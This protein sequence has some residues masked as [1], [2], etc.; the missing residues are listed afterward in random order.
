MAAESMPVQVACK[1][2]G[3]SESGFYENRKRS[4]RPRS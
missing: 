4:R 3:V 1:V 2:L